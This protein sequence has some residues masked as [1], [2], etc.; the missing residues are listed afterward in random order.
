MFVAGKD[1]KKSDK[2]VYRMNRY[3]IYTPVSSVVK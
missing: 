1:T 2:Y 3:F